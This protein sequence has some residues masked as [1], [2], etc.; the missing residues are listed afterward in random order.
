MHKLSHSILI[1][2]IF[3]QLSLVAQQRIYGIVYD[4]STHQTLPYANLFFNN[5]SIG[6]ATNSNGKFEIINNNFDRVNLIISFIGY[7]QKSLWIDISSKETY[8]EIGL[9][10]ASKLLSEIVVSGKGEINRKKYI[11][12][13]E[14]EFLGTN[15]HN[16][17]RILNIDSIDFY[18]DESNSLI[19]R[20]NVPI[21]IENK[22]LGY[23]I[24]FYLVDFKSSSD[25]Y[26][27]KGNTFFQQLPAKSKKQLSEW[28]ANR[29]M[30][31][32]GS[33]QHFIYA[34]K[35]DSLQQDR[36]K[37]YQSLPGLENTRNSPFFYTQELNSTVFELSVDSLIH[38]SQN[39]L[40]VVKTPIEI[41]YTQ[42]ATQQKLY[43]DV[44][45]QVSWLET[46]FDTIRI[47]TKGQLSNPTEIIMAGDM[48][49]Q[50][51]SKMLPTDYQIHLFNRDQSI[52]INENLYVQTNK[53]YYFPSDS[54][55][56]KTY[57]WSDHPS[58]LDSI[59]Q[60]IFIELINPERK[61]IS[62][63]KLN[64][65]A[66]PYG[67]FILP[68]SI[69]GNYFIRAYTSKSSKVGDGFNYVQ[70]PVLSTYQNIDKNFLESETVNG[71]TITTSEEKYKIRSKVILELGFPDA[72]VS[73]NL[74]ISVV[75]STLSLPWSGLSTIYS[76]TSKYNIEIKKSEEHYTDDLSFSGTLTNLPRKKPSA[77]INIIQPS[78]PYFSVSEI[79]DEKGFTFNGVNFYDTLNFMF[80]LSDKKQ[81]PLANIIV[82]EREISVPNNLPV[83]DIP[84]EDQ[85]QKN[86]AD[87]SYKIG[88]K[89]TVLEEVEI[90]SRRI[91]PRSGIIYGKPDKVIFG[92]RLRS[93][94]AGSNLLASM[95]G[96]V[97]GLNVRE[98]YDES[99]IKRIKVTIAG[100]STSFIYV[101]PL[102]LLDG[103]P[104]SIEGLAGI[105]A[106]NVDRI[107]IV[108]KGKP[109]YGARASAG[110][111]S[112]I[113]KT[114][115]YASEKR[116]AEMKKFNVMTL[117]GYK[118][119]N[120]FYSPAYDKDQL[121]TEWF[122]YRS[123]LYWNPQI[124][125]DASGKNQMSFYTGDI[126]GTYKVTVEGIIDNEPFRSVY[127]F[128]VSN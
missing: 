72:V 60:V 113:L 78:L 108:V 62:S 29:T 91:G 73:S 86:R 99:G 118:R 105:P 88:N 102:I 64:S 124:S 1:V 67:L 58:P 106:E 122:D 54:V 7:E 6:T 92:E 80:Q 114:S 14:K 55:W 61:I 75:D 71:I 84:L 97:P 50:R 125:L 45:H 28:K 96:K 85:S 107:E 112:I 37:L 57:F 89:V 8:L 66:T 30:A 117:N 4:S 44:N 23:R 100:A 70:I 68:D 12:L 79:S 10:P 25:G 48:S 32:R 94:L 101:E 2:L 41:H 110:I 26:S 39:Q 103:M 76:N 3:S 56:F 81:T 93:T 90:K 5:T 59:N 21:Q 17:C 87:G 9:N 127:F 36:F 69:T 24:L 95:R 33:L 109:S 82:T 51:I 116:K 53:P 40:F 13:F 46:V 22:E 120:V 77:W 121:D 42:A 115:S 27:I 98:Y 126:E 47:D 15:D 123:T 63:Y 11:Q 16:K 119:P 52:S 35:F 43:S 20:T 38:D 65:V 31:Y 83:T 104:W 19:A 18:E 128:K 34:L 74:S 111:I 49:L